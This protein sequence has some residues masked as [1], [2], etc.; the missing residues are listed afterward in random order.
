MGSSFI[1]SFEGEMSTSGTKCVVF[2]LYSI[3]VPKADPETGPDTKFLYSRSDD[4]HIICTSILYNF[5][6]IIV[7]LE[8]LKTLSS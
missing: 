7:L 1:L 5:M 8:V 6:P 2:A 3:S 4:N